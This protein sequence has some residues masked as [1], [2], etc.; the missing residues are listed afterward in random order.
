MMTYNENFGL[1]P[2]SL[3]AIYRRNNI[4]PADH[5]MMAQ[6]FGNDWPEYATAIA[7]ASLSGRSLLMVLSDL[8]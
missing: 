8:S 1:I 2:A 5:D 3:L 6:C 7:L 4:S